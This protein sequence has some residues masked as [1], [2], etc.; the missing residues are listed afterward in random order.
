MKIPLF[1]AWTRASEDALHSQIIPT[2][3]DEIKTATMATAAINNSWNGNG[4]GLG[5]LSAHHL[6][7]GALSVFVQN[8]NSSRTSGFLGECSKVCLLRCR[9]LPSNIATGRGTTLPSECGKSEGRR[10]RDGEK[11]LLGRVRVALSCLGLLC[12]VWDEAQS[13]NKQW[14]KEQCTRLQLGGKGSFRGEGILTCEKLSRYLKGGL[15]W[16]DVGTFMKTSREVN[17]CTTRK[18]SSALYILGRERLAENQM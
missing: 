8:M 4:T 15:F 10:G 7:L 3:H 18:R 17:R 11:M 2:N 16:P 14:K 1:T 13:L 6:A 9:N 12:S 5:Q